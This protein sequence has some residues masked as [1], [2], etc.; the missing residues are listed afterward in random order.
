MLAGDDTDPAVVTASVRFLSSDQ[1]QLI[2][3]AT[4]LIL[5]YVML[6]FETSIAFDSL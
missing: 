1:L 2:W 6:A 5:F 4:Q 3:D